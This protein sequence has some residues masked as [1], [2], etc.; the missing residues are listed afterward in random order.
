MAARQL[1]E[2][3]LSL[4]DIAI[5]AGYGSQ[6]AF[7]RAF[8]TEFHT[9]PHAFRLK[10]DFSRSRG[11]EAIPMQTDVP[12]ILKPP[13]IEKLN[14][15]NLIGLSRRYDAQSSSQ[16]PDQ[17]ARFNELNIVRSEQQ[18]AYG[19]CYNSDGEG[20]LDY[21][22]AIAVESFKD[23]PGNLDRLR[24]PAQTYAVFTHDGHISQIKG[25]WN[26]IWNGG[27]QEHQ[28]KVCESPQF[29]KYGPQFDPRTGNGG[30]EIWIPVA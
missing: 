30:F 16:I 26:A 29:E 21:L 13:R 20:N 10:P 2:T 17:W 18:A 9:T 23:A 5:N 3:N 12:S 14:E 6:E 4:I 19:V 22:C 8:R 24:L 11:T 7:T 28:L 25:V 1:I 27:I 15:L